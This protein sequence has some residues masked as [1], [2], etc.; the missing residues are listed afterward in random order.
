MEPAV[1][2]LEG[3]ILDLKL[4]NLSIPIVSNVTAKE[5]LDP[6]NQLILHGDNYYFNKFNDLLSNKKLPSV[7]LIS[8]NKGIGKATFIYHFVNYI[9]SKNEDHP[10]N[11]DKNCILL[12]DVLG[13]TNKIGDM[14]FFLHLEKKSFPS[15]GGKSGIINPSILFFLHEDINLFFP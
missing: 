3:S 10:Y 11:F 8:G 4:S 9:L 1:T 7:M 12:L 14:L 5:I 15:S 6:K 2:E 13:A